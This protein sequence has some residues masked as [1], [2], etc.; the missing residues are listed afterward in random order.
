M[1]SKPHTKLIPYNVYYL[2]LKEHDLPVG[3]V[4]NPDNELCLVF[5]VAQSYA[6]IG[7]GVICT[8][9]IQRA[10]YLTDRLERV[11]HESF[12]GQQNVCFLTNRAVDPLR[13]HPRFLTLLEKY[14]TARREHRAAALALI[15]S[16]DLPDIGWQPLPE[17]CGQLAAAVSN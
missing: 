11:H 3:N 13:E 9:M 16:D 12:C 1:P 5:V 15:C 10:D 6:R 17:T 8:T 2:R 14:E 4:D 7:G